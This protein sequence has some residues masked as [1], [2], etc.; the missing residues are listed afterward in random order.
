M[1]VPVSAKGKAYGKRS[2][3][4]STGPKMGHSGHIA[5]G[6]KTYKGVSRLIRQKTSIDEAVPEG[7][8]PYRIRGT[9]F[10]LGIS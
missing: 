9:F 8:T 1:S 5:F 4:A 7:M 6:G 3:G 10:I 2:G